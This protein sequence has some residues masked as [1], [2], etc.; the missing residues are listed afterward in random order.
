M[1]QDVPELR[2]LD[3]ELWNAAKARQAAIK[4]RRGD[5]GREA[6][7]HFRDRRRPKYL[8]PA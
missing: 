4:I 2:I 5:D 7:S 3:D 6:E 1:I 8:F